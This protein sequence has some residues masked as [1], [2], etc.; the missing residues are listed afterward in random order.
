M[1]MHVL[2]H[3]LNATPDATSSRATPWLLNLFTQVTVDYKTLY[4]RQ[5]EITT[6]T[7]WPGF[8]SPSFGTSS[9][10]EILDWV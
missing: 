10:C 2:L 9:R 5:T 6:F 7:T 3:L 1:T 4:Q 8:Q